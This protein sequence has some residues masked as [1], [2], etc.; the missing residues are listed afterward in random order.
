MCESAVMDIHQHL[1]EILNNDTN[2]AFSKTFFRNQIVKQLTTTAILKYKNDEHGKD[3]KGDLPP[4][5][6]RFLCW[7]QLLATI[8]RYC[9]AEEL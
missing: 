1:K 9:H 3:F 4:K 8:W 6:N 7:S 5:S 2:F